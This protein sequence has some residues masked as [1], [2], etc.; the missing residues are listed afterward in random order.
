MLFPLA[1][2]APPAGLPVPAFAGPPAAAGFAGAGAG[3]DDPAAGGG[4]AEATFD[5][6]APAAD[7]AG[8]G[9]GED[10]AATGGVAAEA[11]DVPPRLVTYVTSA[12]ISAAFN[13]SG[14][15]P[16]AFI[17]ALGAFRSA[18]N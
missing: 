14:T 18:V 15:M 7:V 13:V 5:G 2:S 17:L 9:A 12:P 10:D 3:E 4:A 1:A 6:S 16:A 8:A 11:P